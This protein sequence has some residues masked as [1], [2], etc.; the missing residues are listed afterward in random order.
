MLL[1]LVVAK[2]I[3]VLGSLLQTSGCTFNPHPCV[4]WGV[5]PVQHYTITISF[6]LFIGLFFV[7]HKERGGL[8]Q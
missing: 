5:G 8:S 3:K 1:M 7:Y 2:N 6:I 4:E